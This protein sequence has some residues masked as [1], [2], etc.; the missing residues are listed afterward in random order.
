MYVSFSLS[1]SHTPSVISC[2]PSLIIASLWLSVC[3]SGLVWINPAD[4]LLGLSNMPW[5]AQAKFDCTV[6]SQAPEDADW[7]I[8]EV[9]DGECVCVGG[10]IRGLRRR[11]GWWEM[12]RLSDAAQCLQALSPS[13]LLS[14]WV[15]LQLCSPLGFSFSHGGNSQQP[16][17]DCHF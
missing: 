3:L 11:E 7:L 5:L 16:T 2:F 9:G 12:E 4:S 8:L 13:L 1:L 17:L 10:G 6:T 14:F 15:A